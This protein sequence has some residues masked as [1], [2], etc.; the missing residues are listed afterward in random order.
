M[1]RVTHVI[2]DKRI[3]K[4]VDE[5]KYGLSFFLTS[6]TGGFAHFSTKLSSKY[7][8]FFINSSNGA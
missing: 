6:N 2:N 8:G 4:E 5:G 3:S 1:V 7:Q